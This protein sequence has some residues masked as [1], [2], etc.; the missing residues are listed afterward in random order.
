MKI[1]LP[2]D[3]PVSDEHG[4]TKGRV[5]EVLK[6]G[7]REGRGGNFPVWVLGDTGEEVKLWRHEYEVVEE[8]GER[9]KAS[10]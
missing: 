3:V 9:K 6:R 4:M 5:F 8:D 10:N 1:R 7:G 2:R